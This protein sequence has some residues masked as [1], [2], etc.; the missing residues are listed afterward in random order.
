MKNGI[1]KLWGKYKSTGK[2]FL[3]VASTFWGTFV[4][5]IAY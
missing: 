1:N 3:P 5:E 4:F 2:D